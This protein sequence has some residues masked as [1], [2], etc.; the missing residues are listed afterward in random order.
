MEVSFQLWKQHKPINLSFLLSEDGRLVLNRHTHPQ[1]LN[2]LALSLTNM[3]TAFG[4]IMLHAPVSCIL[5]VTL[6][7]HTEFR[8]F[9]RYLCFYDL[10][11]LDM[12]I[13]GQVVQEGHCPQ[14]WD[15]FSGMFAYLEIRP[16]V[17]SGAGFQI[18]PS[19]RGRFHPV[20][21][22]PDWQHALH[23]PEQHAISFKLILPVFSMYIQLAQG[24][25]CNLNLWIVHL[26]LVIIHELAK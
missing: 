7:M 23:H 12:F 13:D 4:S 15:A 9:S 19:S 25:K 22:S 16:T 14:E 17:F 6:H 21:C 11:P 3:W 10:A 1:P 18:R 26:D 8:N 24:M 5:H 20:S 2:M